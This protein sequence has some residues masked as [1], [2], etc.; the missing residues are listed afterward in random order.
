[1]KDSLQQFYRNIAFGR[2]AQ[3]FTSLSLIEIAAPAFAGAG[4]LRSSQ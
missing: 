3:A 1:M 4:L 2:E